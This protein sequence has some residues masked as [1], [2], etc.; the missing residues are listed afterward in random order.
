MGAALGLYLAT[1]HIRHEPRTVR[2]VV[3]EAVPEI[4]PK[5]T[6]ITPKITPETLKQIEGPKKLR[7]VPRIKKGE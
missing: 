1:G 4:T 6:P 2:P 3:L 7:R 5:I